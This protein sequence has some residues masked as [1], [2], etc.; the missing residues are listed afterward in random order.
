MS[1]SNIEAMIVDLS[2]IHLK[3]VVEKV[4]G[5]AAE[6]G[7]SAGWVDLTC[8]YISREVQTDSRRY[9]VDSC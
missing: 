8:T 7:W 6:C 9:G 4:A 1:I 2:L 5:N 3:S